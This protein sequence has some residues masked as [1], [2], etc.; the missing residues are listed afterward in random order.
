MPVEDDGLAPE[1]M[2]D[3]Q[4]LEVVAMLGDSVVAL[5]HCTTAPSGRKLSA[6]AW[7]ALAA[8][9][10][11]IALTAFG[12]AV[13]VSSRNEQ[14][15]RAWVAAGRPQWAFRPQVLGPA[16]DLA[17]A[18]GL[19]LA[20]VGAALGLMRRRRQG[21]S[22]RF[23][24]GSGRGA[25]L[26]LSTA[27]NL[28]LVSEAGR[29][30]VVRYTPEF[31]GELVHERGAVPLAAL[32]ERGWARPGP[33]GCFELA[34]P[35]SGRLNLRVGEV[36]LLLGAVAR[37]AR[38]APSAR[39]L[40]ARTLGYT[41]A[42]AVAHLAVLGLL[43]ATPAEATVTA[44]DLAEALEPSTRTTGTAMEDRLEKPTDVAIGAA[45]PDGGTAGAAM[46][47][48]A[49]TAG[50][51]SKPAADRRLAIKRTGETEQLAREIAIKEAI[52]SGVLGTTLRDANFYAL[53]GTSDLAS[54]L[55]AT[56]AH[57]NLSGGEPGAALGSFGAWYRGFG[58]GGD[59][60]DGIVGV[61]GRYR[62]IGTIPGNGLEIGGCLSA[63][64]CS[65][66]L[67]RTPVAPRVTIHEPTVC[68]GASGCGLDKATIRRYINRVKDKIRYCYE[69]QLLASPEI[70][71]TVQASF[72]ISPTGV[73][74]NSTAA[75]V[76][77]EVS[78]C[79]AG[80]VAS[81]AFPKPGSTG[82]VQVSYPFIFRHAQ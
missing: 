69:K 49:G 2:R 39:K 35:Q 65:V 59:G 44:F 32:A 12:H 7:F 68:G 63:R 56:F 21:A 62:T 79:V 25:E 52:S 54:G 51:P 15:Q 42:S 81:I 28:E 37:P 26:P 55:D 47:L 14:A 4:A 23:R 53:T 6:R 24:V 64:G 73:V 30:L 71:G 72:L 58:P 82:A 70:A 5:K 33:G 17:V 31:Q 74:L 57:G 46:A 67:S 76:H 8:V 60:V 3:D 75:G 11:L 61:E 10:G 40:D 13:Q 9:A 78:Q 22:A 36:T 19:S 27:N 38:S 18:S 45:A 48:E 16:H 80:V 50:D 1:P 77:P 41:G 43:R 66:R 34:M 29:R 20:L